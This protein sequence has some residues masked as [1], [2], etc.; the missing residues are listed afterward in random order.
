MSFSVGS[1]LPKCNLSA[2]WWF[3]SSYTD[4]MVISLDVEEKNQKTKNQQLSHLFEKIVTLFN[5]FHYL[6]L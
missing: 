2:V 3:F 6:Y 4:S 1:L 5:W